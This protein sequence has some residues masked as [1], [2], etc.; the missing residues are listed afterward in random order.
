MS[1]SV[2]AQLA[3]LCWPFPISMA[4]I[5]VAVTQHV[6]S[7]VLRFQLE[8]SLIFNKLRCEDFASPGTTEILALRE[9]FYFSIH[10]A[11]SCITLPSSE[12][13]KN[14]QKHKK[15]TLTVECFM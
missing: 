8:R 13:M 6:A 2:G 7:D 1:T 11:Q 10:S 3:F 14:M 15:A 4:L 12:R 5:C 9:V